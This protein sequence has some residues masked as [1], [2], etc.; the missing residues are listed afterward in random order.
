VSKKN[1]SRIG[2]GIIIVGFFLPFVSV[3]LLLTKLSFSGFQLITGV[4]SS[5]IYG[6]NFGGLMPNVQAI[7]PDAFAIIAF[8]SAICGFAVS[9]IEKKK[10]AIFSGIIGGI[11]V[12]CLIILD[13]H[14]TSGLAGMFASMQ[15]GY[16][17]NILLF[18]VVTVV[19]M[20]GIYENRQ[21]QG[22]PTG[23]VYTGR[24]CENC[25]AAISGTETFC[26]K[27]GNKIS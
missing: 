19:S 26:S 17:I 9:F 3:S 7:K 15:I 16:Y 24:F 27:C 20:L 1:I 5:T 21:I 11:G 10:S 8:I 22:I 6:S 25:G 4:S 13:S 12:I 14:V 2:F 23:R 18:A